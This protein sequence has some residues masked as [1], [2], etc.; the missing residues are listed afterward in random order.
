[1]IVC[2][3]QD[4]VCVHHDHVC[5]CSSGRLIHVPSSCLQGVCGLGAF[6]D[7]HIRCGQGECQPPAQAVPPRPLQTRP[8]GLREPLRGRAERLQHPQEQDEMT[9][10][11]NGVI[12]RS[13][14]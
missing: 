13:P 5:V 10:N 4:S 2:V 11:N 3:P 9:A 8:G 7:G 12:T 14:M 1:M 6:G